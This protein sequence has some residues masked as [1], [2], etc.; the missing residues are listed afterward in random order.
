MEKRKHPSEASVVR[1]RSASVHAVGP[2]PTRYFVIL[3]FS[4]PPLALSAYGTRSHPLQTAVASGERYPHRCYICLIVCCNTQLP[5]RSVGVGRLLMK[6]E[7]R[8]AYQLFCRD[9]FPSYEHH[10]IE[11]IASV[12]ESGVVVA[13]GMTR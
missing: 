8:I 1:C 6:F 13:S 3:L 5:R 7:S 4:T 11:I 10:G 2:E 12:Y 9:A